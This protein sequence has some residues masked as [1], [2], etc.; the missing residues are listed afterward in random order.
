[1]NYSHL[2]IHRAALTVDPGHRQI[3]TRCPLHTSGSEPNSV[4]PSGHVRKLS[5]K[6]RGDRRSATITDK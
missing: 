1:M 4:N 5:H 6:M 3:A 2:A